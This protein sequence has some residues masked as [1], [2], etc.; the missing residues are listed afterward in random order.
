MRVASSVGPTLA[1]MGRALTGS[2]ADWCLAGKG[3]LAIWE[4]WRCESRWSSSHNDAV[5]DQLEATLDTRKL[6]QLGG[7]P[8]FVE[9]ELLR[10]RRGDVGPRRRGRGEQAEKGF[11]P[12][13]LERGDALEDGSEGGGWC[14]QWVAGS[15]DSRQFR[16]AHVVARYVQRS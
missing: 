5:V 7:R 15:G 4:R 8:G 1:E 9:E 13:V 16:N 2:H 6:G 14:A 10:H 3:L 11:R 12:G